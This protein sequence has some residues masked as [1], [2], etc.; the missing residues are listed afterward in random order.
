ME[1]LDLHGTRH[2]EVEHKV[3]RF[4]YQVSLPCKIVTGHSLAM[5]G[6]V[7][8]V[9]KEYDLKSHYENY[10]NNGCLIVTD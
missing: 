9:L 6:I 2:E 7:R 5:K 3:H 8:S 10:V 4:I 1:T